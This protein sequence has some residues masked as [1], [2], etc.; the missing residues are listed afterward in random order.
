MQINRCIG[1]RRTADLWLGC[2]QPRPSHHQPA[3]SGGVGAGSRTSPSDE[4]P[5]TVANVLTTGQVAL[6]PQIASFGTDCIPGLL[7]IRMRTVRRRRCEILVRSCIP[8]T[9][10]NRPQSEGPVGEESCTQ[11]RPRSALIQR[12]EGLDRPRCH[13]GLGRDSRRP[14][15]CRARRRRFIPFVSGPDK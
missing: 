14:Q 5:R 2:V 3:R 15:T 11:L 9:M 1:W 7:A 12:R 4:R 8:W 13:Q 6:L 10:A